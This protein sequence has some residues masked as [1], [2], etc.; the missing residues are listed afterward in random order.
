VKRLIRGAVAG[1][2]AL[3]AL[4]VVPGLAAGAG[5]ADATCNGTLAPGVYRNVV[6]PDNASCRISSGPLVILGSLTIGSGA[7]YVFGTCKARRPGR[8][9]RAQLQ[10]DRGQ[11]HHRRRHDAGL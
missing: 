3:V 9:V 2:V 5:P 6:V 10:H 4:A 7:T 8:R 11:R 1:A